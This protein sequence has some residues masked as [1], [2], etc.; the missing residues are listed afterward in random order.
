MYAY[1]ITINMNLI[2]MAKNPSLVAIEYY[3][4]S[5]CHKWDMHYMKVV[6]WINRAVYLAESYSDHVILRVPSQKPCVCWGK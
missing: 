1:W 2:L 3:K 5:I 6:Q 4:I